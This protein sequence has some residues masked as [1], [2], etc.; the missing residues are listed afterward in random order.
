[1]TKSSYIFPYLK[2]PTKTQ[3]S[4]IDKWIDALRSRKFHQ[5]QHYLKS[6]NGNY[7]CLGVAI[8]V[9]TKSN[10]QKEYPDADSWGHVYITGEDTDVGTDEFETT[11]GLSA[12]L[13]GPLVELN[14]I[15]GK[16]FGVIAKL[17]T[18]IRDAKG[19]F[20]SPYLEEIRIDYENYDS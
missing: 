8:E 18:N 10:F 15:E 7:C 5:G 14:D 2:T 3:K 9:C 13:Q 4:N 6:E 16:K 12:R 20:D 1:M 17:L 19:N 11:F